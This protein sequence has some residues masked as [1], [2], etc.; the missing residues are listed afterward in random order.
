MNQ[1]WQKFKHRNVAKVAAAYAALSWVL[2]Q[3]QEAVLPTI[4]APVW[5][6]QTVLFLLLVGF[7]I[8]CVI[9]WASDVGSDEP[10]EEE[11]ESL[12]RFENRPSKLNG[13]T[14]AL[15]TAMMAVIALFAFYVS[16]YVFDFDPRRNEAT[17]VSETA[18][19][20][21]L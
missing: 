21:V 6:Q 9:A 18:L 3:A 14:I 20:K 11:S 7:P 12:K 2:L 19:T 4:G 15:G 1:F 16:P 13:K 5:V 10:L 8:A 17:I